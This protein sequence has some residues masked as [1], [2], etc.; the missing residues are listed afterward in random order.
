V[1]SEIFLHLVQSAATALATPDANGV[2]QPLVVLKAYPNWSRPQLEPPI[3]ALEI[4][5]L[6]PAGN[7]IGQRAARQVLGLRLYVFAQNEVPGLSDLLEAALALQQ[8]VA[9]FE[10]GG[11]RV[12]CAFSEGQR[13]TNQTGT[14]QEDHGFSWFVTVTFPYQGGA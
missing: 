12:D 14:A 13:H 9:S 10:V 8:A 2:L 4:A 1:I 3:A 11:S 5:S 6:A 7:R